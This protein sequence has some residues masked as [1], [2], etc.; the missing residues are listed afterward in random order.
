MTIPEPTHVAR[1]TP[2]ATWRI[3]ATRSGRHWAENFEVRRYT[4]ARFGETVC[5]ERRSESNGRLEQ[6][7]LSPDDAERIAR[8]ID[9]ARLWEDAT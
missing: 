6:F 3:D 1:P 9:A 2:I 4:D 7:H 8:A 5:I